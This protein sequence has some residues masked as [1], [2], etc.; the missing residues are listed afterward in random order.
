MFREWIGER[1][2][3]Q[4]QLAEIGKNIRLRK[5]IRTLEGAARALVFDVPKKYARYKRRCLEQGKWFRKQDDPQPNVLAPAEADILLLVMLRHARR[6]SGMLQSAKWLTPIESRY[7]MQVLVD[8]ATDF[9]CVQLAAMLELSHPKI[10][11]WLACGDFRQRITREGISSS[12]DVRWIKGVTGV[13]DI[14]I[15]EIRTDYRQSP[16]LRALAEAVA[17]HSC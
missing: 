15:Q 13:D 4:E 1:V 2:L 14:E 5:Q 8:E 17:T 3:P 11:S 7:L 12:D 6:A 16:K 10:R 9:S